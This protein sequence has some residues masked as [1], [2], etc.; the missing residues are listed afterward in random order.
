[1]VLSTTEAEYMSISSACQEVVWLKS[2]YNEISLTNQETMMLFC[3]NKS[4]ID[5]AHNSMYH[6]RSKHIDIC[7]HFIRDLVESGCV[8][9]KYVSSKENVADIF[10]KALPAGPFQECRIKLNI[11]NINSSGDV[12]V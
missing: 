4:A 1:M 10:T 9:I 12:V 3:D 2:L 5:L 8:K 7:H 6:G 11:K